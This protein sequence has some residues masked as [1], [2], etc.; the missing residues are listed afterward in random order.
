GGSRGAWPRRRGTSLA[1]ARTRT[2]TPPI[3][4]PARPACDR[5]A[6]VAGSASDAPLPSLL[7]VV[8]CDG[9]FP[10]ARVPPGVF[11]PRPDVLSSPAP[12]H[13]RSD[14]DAVRP[15][16]QAAGLLL[17]AG[18]AAV[19]VPGDVPAGRTEPR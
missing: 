10:P 16:Q 18:H 2:A 11:L 9:G 15:A 8:R 1:R 13:R 5:S 19:P 14:G 17:N 12:G 3:A 4:A 6:S 7:P